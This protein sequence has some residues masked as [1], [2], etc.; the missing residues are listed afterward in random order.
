MKKVF[1]ILIISAL[2]LIP[3]KVNATN[4]VNISCGKTKLNKNEETSCTISVNNLNFKATDITGKI[5]VGNNLSITSSSYDNSVWL[6]LASKFTV[7]DLDLMKNEVTSQTSLTVATFKVKASANATGTSSITFDN[8]A[9]GND[10]Y[11]SIPLASKT[12]NF[13]FT[14]NVNTLSSLSVAGSNIDFSPDKTTYNLT[15]DTASVTINATPTHSGARVSGAGNRNLNYGNNTINIVV[16]AEDGSTKTYTINITRPDNRSQN[17]NLKTLTVSE[18]SIKFNKTTTSYNVNVESNITKIN[19]NASVEDSKASFENGYGPRTVNLNYGNNKIQVRVK[20]ENGAVKTYTINVNRKDNR[21]SNNTLKTL[22][23]SKGKIDFDASKTDYSITV[24][25]EINSIEVK[26][27]AT[28]T[29][30]KVEIIGNN[31]EL[32]VGE[33]IIIIKVTAE[34]QSVKEYKIKVIKEDK[35]VITSTNKLKELKVEGYEL[36]F[37]EDVYSYDLKVKE[38]KLKITATPSDENAK[39]K[40]TGNEN[41]KNGSIILITVTDKDGN[42]LIYKINIEKDEPKPK[43]KKEFKISNLPLIISILLNIIFLIIIIILLIKRKSKNDENDDNKT[44][45]SSKNPTPIS[46]ESNTQK[47]KKK[48]KSSL[49]KLEHLEEQPVLSHLA[50]DKEP[51]KKLEKLDD[52]PKTRVERLEQTEK[53]KELEHL[54]EQPILG[55]LDENKI[56]DS[57]VI[58]EKLDTLKTDEP[59][60]ISSEKISK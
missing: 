12:I 54:E 2:L 13:S 31:K 27:T 16:T 49:P 35:V 52:K 19:I 34:N 1:Y 42:N 26:A 8:V 51:P 3:S 15:L 24:P 11:Q 59:I 28:D 45:P 55:H 37:S 9:M 5:K 40:I 30:S 4:D 21:S 25:N 50:E 58:T 38:S 53:A 6:S 47:K 36:D 56:N 22:T 57:P 43:E 23:L 46:S 29:K 44:N 17:N 32:I 39:Y 60:I 14:S 20:A 10:S 41:L 7:E 33:N 18:G 48:T